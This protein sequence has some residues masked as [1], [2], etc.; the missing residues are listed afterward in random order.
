MGDLIEAS[1]R[2]KLTTTF[3]VLKDINLKIIRYVELQ[4]GTSK[5]RG[6]IFQKNLSW[7]LQ[8]AMLKGKFIKL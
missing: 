3:K 7:S 1:H 8:E 5:M 4:T 2:F 6:F